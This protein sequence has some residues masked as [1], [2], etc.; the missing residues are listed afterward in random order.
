MKPYFTDSTGTIVIY[1]GD[2]REILPTIKADVV[3]TSPPYN[4]LPT[5]TPSGLWGKRNGGLGFAEACTNGY[6][7]DRPES[8]YKTF[9]VNVFDSISTGPNAS[10][11]L[12]HKLRWRNK[13]LSHPVEWLKFPS[14]T[15]RQELV[16]KR[17]GSMTFNARIFPP[18][19][20]RLLWFTR[21]DEWVFDQSAANKVLSVW[22]L[23]WVQNTEHVCEYPLEIPRRAINVLSIPGHIVLDPFMGSGT[24]LVAAKLEGRRAIGI[25]IEERYAEIAARRL[26]QEMLCFEPDEKSRAK[27]QGSLLEEVSQ[28]SQAVRQAS[29]RSVQPPVQEGLR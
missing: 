13:K 6:F 29:V 23:T 20:E 2:C 25:E 7:D 28:E 22:P 12:N 3:V 19:D 5:G 27:V 4:T 26:D 17:P 8:E 10:L 1:H 15:L 9:I 21:G 18:S 14:W 16:W 11:F 24:T